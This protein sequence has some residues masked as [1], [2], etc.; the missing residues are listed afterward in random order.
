MGDSCSDQDVRIDRF[1]GLLSLVSQSTEVS[2]ETSRMGKLRRR[3]AGSES[4]EVAEPRVKHSRTRTAS[5]GGT[6][7]QGT[8]ISRQLFRGA[9]PRLLHLPDPRLMPMHLGTKSLM[10]REFKAFYLL[11]RF[12]HQEVLQTCRYLGDVLV[13]P[14]EGGPA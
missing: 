11:F 1:R 3:E 10:L 7:A 14:S 4:S 6:R 2:S 13:F 8:L 12:K 5:V 9:G